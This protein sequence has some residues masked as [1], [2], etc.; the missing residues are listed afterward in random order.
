ME[1]RFI[2]IGKE[3]ANTLRYLN[4]GHTFREDL[5]NY[6]AEVRWNWFIADMSDDYSRTRAEQRAIRDRVRAELGDINYQ[7]FLK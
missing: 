7:P 5:D 3:E 4:P 6:M 2:E 1:E